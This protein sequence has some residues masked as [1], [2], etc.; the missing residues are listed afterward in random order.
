MAHVGHCWWEEALT[1]AGTKW[2]LCVDIS[3]WQRVCSSHP[4]KF[5]EM[6]RLALDEIGPW[7]VMYGTDNPY[8]NLMLPSKEWI[9]GVQAAVESKRFSFSQEEIDIIMGAAAARLFNIEG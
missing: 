6:L 9:A 1:L 4:G 5:Y 3:G 2:N 7:R 8:L